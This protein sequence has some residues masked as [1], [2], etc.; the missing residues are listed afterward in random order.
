MFHLLGLAA[1]LY[2]CVTAIKEAC[3]PTIPAENWANRELYQQDILNGV[4]VE[5]RMK[6]L[7]DGKYRLPP[8]GLAKESKSIHK[9]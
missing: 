4:P 7:R 5:Q 9:E 6:N 2:V 1:L 3:E 8:E